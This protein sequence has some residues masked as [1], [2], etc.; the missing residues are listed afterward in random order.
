VSDTWSASGPEDSGLGFRPRP[1]VPIAVSL[2]GP[3]LVAGAV[4]HWALGFPAL[5]SDRVL[6]A[7]ETRF[8]PA[9]DSV[10]A[11]ASPLR[12]E[13]ARGSPYHVAA[14]VVCE[15]LGGTS[16]SAEAG[17]PQG[18]DAPGGAASVWC[19]STVARVWADIA[20]A[21]DTWGVWLSVVVRG[22][23]RDVPCAHIPEEPQGAEDGDV[24]GA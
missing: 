19:P 12:G 18:P 11:A 20:A 7:V 15:T 8:A 10:G 2:L 17:M 1:R 14:A 6:I 21:P 4:A 3:L 23:H 13:P 22:A 5:E 24:H 16:G 9:P